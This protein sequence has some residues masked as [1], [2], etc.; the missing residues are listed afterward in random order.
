VTLR[1]HNSLTRQTEA[2]APL[3]PP[4][5]TLYTCGPTVWNF[6]HIGNFRT[7]V[8][9]DVLRR[10][11][12]FAGYEVA[13]VMNL[14]DVDDRTIAAAGQA[15]VPLA[16]HTAPFAE[17][18]FADCRYLRIRPAA[19]YPRA[20]AFVPQMVALVQ[21]LLDGGVAY[22]GEDGSVY[23]AIDRFP[24]YGRLSQV[25]RR[26]LRAG[27]RVS[28][29]EYDKADARDFVLWKA[30]KPE[31]EAVGAAWDAPFGRGRPGWH[32][33]CSAMAQALL[34]ET[35]DIHAGGVDLMFPH[36]EDEIAQSEAAT[37][38]PFVRTW[39]HAEFLQVGGAKMSKRYGNIVTARD[40][41]EDGWDA[42]AIRTL[43]CSTHYRRQLQFTD[44][45]LHAA[46]RG[47]ARLAEFRARLAGA[48]PAA[49]PGALVPLAE[50]L[51][52]GFR[53]AMDDDLDAPRALAALMDFVRDANRDLDG[54]G[55]VPPAERD[56]ALVAFDR[57]AAVLQV[58]PEAAA[59]VRVG[60]GVLGLEGFAPDASVEPAE[61]PAA[62]ED[63]GAI[64][65][66][67]D[68]DAG[69]EAAWAER[70]ARL[71]FAARQRKDWARA[72]AARSLLQARGFE[73]RD[74]KDGVEVVKRRKAPG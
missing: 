64:P 7:F 32:L 5:V 17:A 45:A 26:E 29:D 71:R 18:F 42:A 51:D 39:L 56:E 2:F 49:A 54:R 34:G 40:L 12:E 53:A 60:P 33:E 36:H 59:A 9:E 61:G 37:G 6:A 44:D 55:G 3:A 30:A 48:A 19:H 4:R 13:H 31:D 41:R 23:F 73:V 72:D 57:V 11:L 22:R 47:A 65:P 27:A 14:T 10:Y 70:L 8:F 20:T 52:A 15:G 58:V 21:R 24:S 35:V 63:P 62:A 50:R 68:G 46:A 28:S 25:D 74:T 66:P 16:V 43:F 1:L 69:A 38:K 67:P